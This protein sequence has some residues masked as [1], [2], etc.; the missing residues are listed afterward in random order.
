MPKTEFT[1][2]LLLTP[3][4]ANSLGYAK[5]NNG[6]HLCVDIPPLE[7]FT[8]SVKTPEGKLVT[9]AFIPSADR[10]PAGTLCVDIKQHKKLKDDLSSQRVACWTPGHP[11]FRSL[12]IKEPVTLTVLNFAD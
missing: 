5:Y 8:I 6:A 1:P 4:R 11:V 2:P 3:L 10:A 7:H 12:D 9:F